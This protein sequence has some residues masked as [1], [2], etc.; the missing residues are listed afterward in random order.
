[1]SNDQTDYQDLYTPVILATTTNQDQREM[2]TD[3]LSHKL[4]WQE[5]HSSSPQLRWINQEQDTISIE[6]VRE[7][8]NELAYASHLNKLRAFVLLAADKLSSP[9]Q[10]ALLKSLEESPHKTQILLMTTYPESLLPTIRSRCFIHHQPHHDLAVEMAD[11]KLSA[12]LTQLLT[13]PPATSYAELIKLA[14]QYKDRDAAVVLIQQLL[15]SLHQ[16]QPP[17]ATQQS[18][19]V[20]SQLLNTLNQLQANLNVRLCLENCFF[21]IK[22]NLS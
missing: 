3:F 4:G 2:A 21:E 13:Q 6:Q 14:A 15:I 20:Q 10:H 8:I 22:K 11:I 1:M 9:A 16:Q 19:K 5:I 12:K 18:I 7:L 17:L